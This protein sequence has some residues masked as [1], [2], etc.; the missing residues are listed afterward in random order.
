[1]PFLDL[2]SVNLQYEEELTKAFAEV[3]RS[4][5]FVLGEKV[6]EF[7]E[8]FAQYCGVK[9]CIGVANGL[10]ALFMIFEAY[11]ELGVMKVGHEVIV[12]ANTFIASILA[13]SKAGLSPVLVEARRS[14]YLIDVSKIEKSITSR[15]I[16]I[17][18]VHLFGQ[19][20]DMD[21]IK[22]LA[23]KYSLKVV[24]DCAQAH[25]AYYRG[26]RS[27]NLSDAAGF[28][29]YPGKN[30]GALG[31]GGAITTNDDALARILNAY[32]N[33]GSKVKYQHQFK[34]INSR[35]DELQ[36]A[37]LTVKLKHLDN[38]TEKRRAIVKVYLQSLN[39]PDINLPSAHTE[40]GHVWHLF[41]IRTMH[42]DSL[43]KFLIENGVMTVIHYPKPPHLQQAFSNFGY[44]VG[45]F[46]ITE[47]LAN[48]SLS[49]PLWPCMSQQ[50]VQEVCDL[51]KRF[52]SK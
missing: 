42:R 28:S 13:I 22:A 37:F 19:V 7:E 23:K 39:V 3:L 52:F 12:P 14:D 20:C 24:E 33:Y 21:S 6:I 10:D 16:A 25:G 50:Q 45:D 4:G 51:I 44:H 47:E 46:P 8:L 1:M 5:W 29:F 48:T 26:N 32:R 49:L 27:G 38:E 15:T 35:L 2:R 18:P 17:M 36:A 9:H 31:D 11:K 34:G 40:S 41:V 43:Q 30:L